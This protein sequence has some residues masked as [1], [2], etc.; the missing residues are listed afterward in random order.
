M[1]LRLL[2]ITILASMMVSCSIQQKPLEVQHWRLM[3][4][5]SGSEK[6]NQVPFWL[7]QGTI[8]I[9]SPFDSKSFVYR[10]DDQN[11]E[12]DFY[13]EYTTLPSEMLAAATRQ[14][15]NKAGIFQFAVNNGNSLLPLYLLQ[16]TVDEMYI[17]FRKEQPPA[18]VFT[19]E[20]FLSSSDG[21]RKNNVLF[22][23][24]YTQRQNISDNSAKSMAKAQQIALGKILAQLE[25]D[26]L[27]EASSFPKP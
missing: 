18:A 20:Y 3:P 23:K 7:T 1:K 14:W 27:K 11:Y 15:L 12:K 22:R 21:A 4:D 6:T 19:V 8:G 10:L 16:G 17:D 24:I 25:D 5:R 2:I 9:A 13:N 26:L